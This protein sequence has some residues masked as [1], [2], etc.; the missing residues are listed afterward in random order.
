MAIIKI[1][2]MVKRDF[3]LSISYKPNHWQ[4]LM[5]Y[6]HKRKIWKTNN[7]SPSGQNNG[8]DTVSVPAHLLINFEKQRKKTFFFCGNTPLK[9]VSDLAYKK[10]GNN[11]FKV[12]FYHQSDFDYGQAWLMY[13]IWSSNGIWSI[14]NMSRHN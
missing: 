7:N 1:W 6:C 11:E 12:M 14:N 13:C 2:L 10:Y 8:S 3:K 5:V 4:F 9:S